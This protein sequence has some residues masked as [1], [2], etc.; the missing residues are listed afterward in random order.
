MN[1]GP[2][3]L[4]GRAGMVAWVGEQGRRVWW[5]TFREALYASFPRLNSK[6]VGYEDI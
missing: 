3:G 4:G 5:Y 1:R 6:Q 2:P